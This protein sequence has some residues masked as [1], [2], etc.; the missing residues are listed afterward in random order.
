MNVAY[1][2]A[3]FDTPDQTVEGFIKLV[4]DG[5]ENPEG[6]D[7]T[8]RVIVEEFPNLGFRAQFAD[9]LLVDRPSSEYDADT[10]ISFP[11]ST[12]EL[13][14]REFEVV[15]WRSPEIIGSTELKGDQS[16]AFL[17]AFSCLRPSNWT[18]DRFA[19]VAEKH[20]A[21][22]Y[23]DGL[24]IER[25]HAPSQRQLLQ[26]MDESRPVVITGLEPTPP[27]HDWSLDRIESEYG[28]VTAFMRSASDHV[29]MRR[30]VEELRAFE[31]TPYKAR[32]SLEFK[33]YT[34]G[35]RLPNEMWDNFGS[36]YFDREDFVPPQLW[37][38]SVPTDVPAT[39][40]HRDPLTGFLFQVMGR[41]RLDLYSADQADLLYPYKSYNTYQ[42]CWFQPDQ[43]N[44]EKYPKAQQA[45]CVS[46]EL[47]PGEL[48]VQPAG[49]FHQV[50]ALDS[51]TMSVS[52]FWRY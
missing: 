27:C 38:G 33:A 23:R 26:A 15:D 6:R 34:E 40:L 13:I 16:L 32:S 19:A 3:E 44:Y 18:L 42:K 49:W 45:K 31:D 4:K 1:P 36:M 35:S 21:L 24:E 29:T 39:P 51:P 12:L 37:L 20:K 47:H 14:F 11:L 7:G 52:Y 9:E 43:P 10:E 41:K 8:V 2:Q 50:Y 46:V 25:L 22:G 30:F 5:F 17:L 48:L 28:D